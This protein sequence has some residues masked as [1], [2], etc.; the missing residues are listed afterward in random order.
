VPA[1]TDTAICI[2]RWDFSETSQTV[3][4]FLRD[5]GLT[6][7][8]VKGAKRSGAAFDG[9]IDLLAAGEVVAWIRPGGDLATIAQWHL[10]EVH[11]AL[12]RSL[13]ANRA[14]LYMAD[15]VNHM[16]TEHDPH[17]RLFDALLAALA[18]LEEPEAIPRALLSFSWTLLCETG[19]RPRLDRDAATGEPLP[20]GAATLAF[21][22][23]AGGAV[24]DTGG[25]DR[26]RVRRETIELL[27]ALDEGGAPPAASAP[28]PL[29]RACRLLAAYAREIIGDEPRG[30]RWAFPELSRGP[31]PWGRF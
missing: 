7:G 3:C 20:E 26:W 1:V 25:T 11:R 6:R 10:L 4:L 18:S 9:G 5:H 27:R 22:A 23:S 12:R 24:A 13:D 21:S 17:P 19:Y 14:G 28:E 29:R 15:L 30:M 31:R 16:L 2:R 8:I